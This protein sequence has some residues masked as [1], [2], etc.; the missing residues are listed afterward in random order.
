MWATALGEICIQGT[1][2]LFRQVSGDKHREEAMIYSPMHISMDSVI[3][4]S[5]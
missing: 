5:V 4:Y 2:Y 3:H 1:S